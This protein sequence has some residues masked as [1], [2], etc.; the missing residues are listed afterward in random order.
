MRAAT[1]AIWREQPED[2][3]HTGGYRVWLRFADGLEGE[4]DPADEL[5]GPVFEPLNDQAAFAAL[6]FD[7]ELRT[8]VWPNS[9]DFTPGFL[10]QKVSELSTDVLGVKH[11][12]T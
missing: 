11:V 6:H 8:I 1:W 3:K 5:W 10:R 7:P 2:A 4:A 9:A 12:T